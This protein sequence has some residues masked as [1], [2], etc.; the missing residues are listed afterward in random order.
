[1]CM[2]A[3]KSVGLLTTTKQ[4]TRY[5]RDYPGRKKADSR[6]TDGAVDT[7][8]RQPR[9]SAGGGDGYGGG[10]G[11]GDAQEYRRS[12]RRYAPEEEEDDEYYG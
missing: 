6:R 7:R 1:M 2:G 8:A 4:R 11:G 10:K 3:D 12:E 5:E 9:R